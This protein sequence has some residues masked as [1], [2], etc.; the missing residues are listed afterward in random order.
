[1]GVGVIRASDLNALVAE[2]DRLGGLGTPATRAYLSDFRFVPETCV[3]Q[4]LDPFSEEYFRQQEA[5]YRE[6][7]GRDL[8]Q[9]EGERTP[10]DVT[11]HAAACNPYNNPDIR[12]IARHARAIQTCLV[13]ADLPPGAAA[14]DLGCG[15]GLSSEMM[16]FAGARVTAVDINPPFVEL[17]RRRAA[18]L[19][20]PIE[21]VESDFDSYSD[22]RR[23]D[24]VL[25]YECLHHSLRPWVTLARIGPLVKPG[26]KIVWA[27]EPV[28]TIWWAD[29]GLRLD[30][31]SVYCM[32]KYGWW[33]SGWSA[34]FLARCFARAGFAMT[35]VPGVG[36]DGTP[37]GFAVRTEDAE[38][39]RPDRSVAAAQ[40]ELAAGREQVE[41]LHRHVAAMESSL[42]WRL[43]APVRALG[44]LSRRLRGATRHA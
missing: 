1:M 12:F 31:D 16:A 43:A 24:L 34:E 20:L 36:L 40:D 14:L 7:A 25:F 28:N 33:E 26:G 10:L 44:R 18:R 11:A 2:C 29:W 39:V 30:H 6:I 9:A 27:G 5:L 13:V 3:D 8:N 19:G 38:R 35:V 22:D 4:S 21:A 41:A 15:W 42:S 23:Y 17:V 32:R 37:V